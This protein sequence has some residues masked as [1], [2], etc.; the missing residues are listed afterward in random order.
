MNYKFFLECKKAFES[1]QNIIDLV[2]LKYPNNRS[3]SIE[4]A[5]DLQAGSYIKDFY[6]NEKKK[7]KYTNECGDILKQYVNNKTEILNVG[8]GE[9]W[10]ISLMLERSLIKP[11]T[12]Y[13][14]ELSWSRIYKGCSFWRNIHGNEIIMK[15][16]VANMLEIP[17]PSNSVDI[18]TSSH[19]L[20]PNG[21]Q[22]QKIIAELFRVSRNKC[23]L[24]EPY[25][26]T[27]S[28]EGKDRMDRHGYIKGILNTVKQLGGIVEQVIPIKNV[29]NVLNPTNCFIITTP[30]G[31]VE[32]YGNRH[33]TVPGTE[34][35]L[36]EKEGCYY[37]PNTGL[38]FPI[39]KNIP[40]FKNQNAILASKY[41]DTI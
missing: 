29:A 27:C 18:I 8:A 19:A 16:F 1:K 12:V 24:F 23:I 3:L 2:Q 33:F 34:Y 17:L 26:E 21:S 5:Y 32:Y 28:Q 15:P 11:K 22:L 37:S 36:E 9:L 14:L 40:I 10:T 35:M 20:E 6:N 38:A 25:Y 41:D 31:Q 7:R 4:I 39:I 13:N 30:R